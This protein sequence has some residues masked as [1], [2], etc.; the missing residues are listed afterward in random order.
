MANAFFR[1]GKI[2]SW[3]LTL[4]AAGYTQVRDFEFSE[5]LWEAEVRSANT[6]WQELY[7]EPKIGEIFRNSDSSLTLIEIAAR[8]ESAGY[9]DVRDLGREGGIWE[10]EAID[11]SGQRVELRLAGTDGRVLHS[12]IDHNASDHSS[13]SL[14]AM[15]HND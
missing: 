4:N 6:R 8:L 3:A 5:G 12:E 7:I 2:E 11:S 14:S 13:S 10:A 15:G 9:R 1:A